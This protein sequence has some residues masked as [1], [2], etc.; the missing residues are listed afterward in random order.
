MGLIMSI[1]LVSFVLYP[2]GKKPYLLK[3]MA[4][5]ITI[6]LLSLNVWQYV[7]SLQRRTFAIRDA[8]LYMAQHLD[9][10]DL[11][12][13]AWAPALTWESKA[14]SIPV[15]NH[16]LNDE[17]P[18]HT[19]HPK[20]IVTETDEQDAEQTWSQQGIDLVAMA[21]SSRTFRIGYWDVVVYWMNSER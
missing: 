9:K 19:F 11:V 3:Y 16:F 10:H 17:D 1:I 2:V 5:L 12:L 8:K 6:A 14:R 18:I 4:G 13:G 21:D 20:A 7:E 15:W